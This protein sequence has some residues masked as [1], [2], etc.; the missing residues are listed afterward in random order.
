MMGVIS[1]PCRV[2]VNS[3]P[4]ST[5]FRSFG[6]VIFGSHTAIVATKHSNWFTDLNLV[7]G[8]AACNALRHRSLHHYGLDACIGPAPRHARETHV[9]VKIDGSQRCGDDDAC[10]T[11]L[12]C[13]FNQLIKQ[14]SANAHALRRGID[15]Q[16]LDGG[17]VVCAGAG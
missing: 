3:S 2:V 12:P 11:S 15:E 17:H 5:R 8:A 16:R 7:L 6:D 10:Q 13:S 9:R 1:L 4:S 14:S